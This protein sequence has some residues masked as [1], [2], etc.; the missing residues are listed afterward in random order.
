M[1]SFPIPYPIEAMPGLLCE[2]IQ[3][4][5]CNVQAPL[6]LCAIAALTTVSAAAQ[7]KI[8]VVMPWGGDPKPVGV[9]FAVIA[10]SGE[11]KTAV[12]GIFSKPLNSR[13]ALDAANY[14]AAIAEYE[15]DCR[16]WQKIE[17]VLVHRIV[18]QEQKGGKNAD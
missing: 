12:D 16:I 8:K 11:R 4:V 10:E 15:M 18:A 9:Y 13:D 3:Q 14:A 5:H 7:E 1:N 6:P 17:N 2:A